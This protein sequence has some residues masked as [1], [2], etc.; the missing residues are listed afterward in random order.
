MYVVIAVAFIPNIARQSFCDEV[1]LDGNG[2]G[3]HLGRPLSSVILFS[4]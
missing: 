1:G 4:G 3:D 2:F